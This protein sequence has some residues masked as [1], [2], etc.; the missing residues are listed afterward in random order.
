ME[1]RGAEKG[2]GG[3]EKRPNIVSV[4]L[5]MLSIIH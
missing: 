5:T 1:L 4:M 3:N 2:I